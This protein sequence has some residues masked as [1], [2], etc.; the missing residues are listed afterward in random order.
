MGVGAAATVE[1]WTS[2]VLK[3]TKPQAACVLLRCQYLRAICTFV[4]V[5]QVNLAPNLVVTCRTVEVGP[6]DL[7]FVLVKLLYFWTGKASKL[8]SKLRSRT[9]LNSWVAPK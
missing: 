5:K 3:V 1:S 7:S 9:H 8:R 2:R 6:Q 4:L